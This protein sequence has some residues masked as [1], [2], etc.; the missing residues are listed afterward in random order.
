[1]RPYLDWE[2]FGPR[3]EP[4]KPPVAKV[5]QNCFFWGGK[6]ADYMGDC[7]NQDQ[8]YQRRTPFDG[9]CPGFSQTKPVNRPTDPTK[10]YTP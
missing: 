10:Y 4:A 3:P 8:N 9:T 5:C 1:M 6:S 7:G 2:Q